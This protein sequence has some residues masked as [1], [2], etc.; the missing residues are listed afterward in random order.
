VLG[1]TVTATDE[2]GRQ[3]RITTDG[4]GRLVEV[5][6][7]QASDLGTSATASVAITGS[8]Q[9]AAS[10][11]GSP[12]PNAAS[13][14]PLSAYIDPSGTQHF[15]YFTGN[16][17]IDQFFHNSSGWGYNDGTAGASSPLAAGSS[18]STYTTT[19]GD[20]WI[21]LASDQHVHAVYWNG[22]TWGTND[23][24][25]WSGAP[26]PA[27]GSALTSFL[28]SG[29]TY[30]WAFEGSNQHLYEITYNNTTGG[31]YTDMT[32]AAGAPLAAVGSSLRSYDDPAGQTWVYLASDQH[33]H[34]IYL[35][36]T[37]WGTNDA[38]V[39]SGAPP[40]AAGSALSTLKDSGGTYRWAFQGSNQH[41][42]QITYNNA[43]GG[44]YQDLT[45]AAG[46]PVAAAGSALAS[47]QVGQQLQW[48]FLDTN[49]HV[50]HI[51][52]VVGSTSCSWQ[53]LTTATGSPA[54]AAGSAL[55]A[56]A[57]PS[58]LSYWAYVGSN[59]HVYEGYWTGNFGYNDLN[60][61]A[62][63]E[64]A[65]SG[66]VSLNIGSFTATACFGPS[67][68]PACTGQ[69]VNSSIYQ[70]ASALAQAINIGSS[71]ATATVSGAAISLVWKTPG[72]LTPSVSALSTTHDQPGLFAN[73]S[74]T[75]SVTSATNGTGPSFS[76]PYTTLYAYDLLD[77]L[78]CV[79]QHGNTTGTG[80]TPAV[81]AVTDTQPPA[82]DATSPWR[83]RR[84]AYDS[85]SR[86]RWAND[87]ESGLSSNTY[88]NN[89]N[90]LT[91]TDAR[92]ITVN[93]SPSTSPID[94]LNR[95]TMT[96]YS[97]GTPG[98]TNH[99]DTSCCGV[100][101][102]NP[103]GRLTSANSGNTEL[104]FSYDP[105]GRILTQW[106]CPPSGIAR[107]SC[108]LISALY[109]LAGQMTSLTYPDGRTVTTGYNGAG[110]MTGVTLAS[111]GG[112]A[113]NI[114]Y[115]TVPQSTAASSWGYLPSGAMNRGTYG[116]GVV[117][118]LGYNNRLSLNSIADI[119]GSQTLLS[120]SY[121]L[122]DTSGHTNGNVLS[123]VDGLSTSANQ[124]YAYDELNR[125]A[126]GSQ[127]DNT[128]NVT[129]S[130][131]PWGN[132]KQS[133]TSNFQPNYDLH[134]RI[135]GA[136]SN[137]TSTT[138]Y[139]YDAAGNLLNDGFHAYAYDGDGRM[140]SVDGTGATYTY[141]AAGHRVRKDASTSSAEYFFLGDN[142]I[143]ELS[144][145][146]N[147][148][149][150]Y[151]FGYEDRI[152]SD[153]SAN[154]TG[155][156]YFHNDQIGSTRLVTDNT[157]AA[158][159]SATYS[160]FGQELSAQSSGI[161]FQYAG[162]QYDN[163]TS[164]SHSAFRQYSSSEGR[165]LAPDPY[166]ESLDPANP[167]S[168]N[169][170]VYVLD[171][172]LMYRDPSGLDCIYDAD[173]AKDANLPGPGIIRGDCLSEKDGG[174][175]VDGTI[176]QVTYHPDSG[177][178]GFSGKG[179]VGVTPDFNPGPPSSWSPD[180]VIAAD[181]QRR[182]E[183]LDKLNAPLLPDVNA[184]LIFTLAYLRTEHDLG[185]IGLGWLGASGGATLVKLGQPVPGSKPFVGQ[186][187]SVGTSPAS[188]TLREALPQKLPFRVP[189]PV[190]GP[191]TGTPLRIART[192]SLGAVAGRYAP[193]IG[194]AAMGYSIYKTNQCLGSKP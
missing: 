70:V 122:Y 118:T 177:D 102:L 133:G 143:A 139:C 72:P 67:T 124:T 176:T 175:F 85:L 65:D 7:P 120:K 108:Y 87:P 75:S 186:G 172:P 153:T 60:A 123:I 146:S 35:N 121:G 48:Y 130:Y 50:D 47:Y 33:I 53:D 169:R 26:P 30:R 17:H 97:D 8:M 4:F 111:F 125:I 114:P 127:T 82:N 81:M 194:L 13:G 41:L 154:G 98:V 110:R 27:A 147:T 94:A 190:G 5:D 58:T 144:I 105:M 20:G 38:M 92:G 21:Y 151:I 74:F 51:I 42:Y 152:A 10:S 62:P 165:W 57:D 149:T 131:D 56:F 61:T 1:Q 115:Y 156:R 69:P 145:T 117:E 83:V 103:V 116:N 109:D 183:F 34:G 76:N 119:K 54:A 44:G 166:L 89:G 46:A 162:M 141:N 134:N 137:C 66:T 86:L 88:D 71:P 168:L 19:G 49:N 15:V 29:G 187:T 93:F 160:P 95:V 25:V 79:E 6:E 36:S 126:S 73:P 2:T 3:R 132:M 164:L 37:G 113:V 181:R 32:A 191:G 63:K 157:G 18:L 55:T 11:T 12:A 101:S 43:T 16:Q 14:S 28:D 140:R 180:D 22:T 171:N 135:L 106:D 148:W 68:N 159:W 174:V 185:C 193:F 77:N 90:L 31:G 179:V 45:A 128:F 170:Y 184:K 150:D 40:A 112:T 78:T 64:V 182:Q 173:A 99:Y 23:A 39:W 158:I 96:T 80:C 155:A 161:E 84:F 189:T 138:T 192:N 104:V 91:A 59:Q 107:G 142:V 9:M 129:F 188:S 136:P 163:E 178:L 167:Q 52:C 24:T 100:T